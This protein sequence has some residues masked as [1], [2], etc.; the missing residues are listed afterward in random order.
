MAKVSEAAQEV[1]VSP[2]QVKGNTQKSP[3]TV[4]HPAGEEAGGG[5][6]VIVGVIVV[7][8][9][10]VVVVLMVVVVVDVLENE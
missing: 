4:R 8:V 10:V 6:E 1:C 7:V 2:F 9:A 5:D 3:S